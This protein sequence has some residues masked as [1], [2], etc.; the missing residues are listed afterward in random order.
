MGRKIEF[1]GVFCSFLPKNTSNAVTVTDV[2][3]LPLQKIKLFYTISSHKENS[4]KSGTFLG[5]Y[6]Q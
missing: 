3:M 1:P 6:R 2:T 4:K 5:L